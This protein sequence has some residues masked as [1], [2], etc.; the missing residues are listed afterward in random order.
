MSEL[1]QLGIYHEHEVISEGDVAAAAVLVN[2]ARRSGSIEPTVLAW[3]AMCLA[4][5]TSRD[6]AQMCRLR[7]DSGMGRITHVQRSRALSRIASTMARGAEE[8]VAAC[9]CER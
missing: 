5:R 2:I 3:V 8:C 4:L 6:G 1:Q 7:S 9:W